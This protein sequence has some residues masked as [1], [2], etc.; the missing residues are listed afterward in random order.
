[1]RAGLAQ[2]DCKVAKV[3]S[4]NEEYREIVFVT[5]Q[6]DRPVP[7]SRGCYEAEI[8]PAEAAPEKKQELQ[9]KQKR[10][11]LA[12]RLKQEER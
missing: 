7:G 4:S 11:C 1:M 6:G 9:E 8:S 5:P 12:I 3:E 2:T 10:Q